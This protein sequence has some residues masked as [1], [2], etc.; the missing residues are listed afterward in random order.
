VVAGLEDD[1]DGGADVF[2]EAVAAC[3]AA[4]TKLT[5]ATETVNPLS[6]NVACATKKKGDFWS[7]LGFLDRFGSYQTVTG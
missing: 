1:E 3:L 7:L 4:R 6:S 2:R 5:I